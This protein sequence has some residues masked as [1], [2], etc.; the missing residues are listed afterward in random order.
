METF[1]QFSISEKGENSGKD[2][3]GIFK[4]KTLLT[5]SDMFLSDQRRRDIL[6]PNAES[7]LD[8]LKAEAFMLGQLFVR[9]V[10]SPRFWKDSNYGLELED[11]N[12]ISVLFSKCMDIETERK[13]NLSKS[14]DAAKQS[15]IKKDQSEETS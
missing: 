8:A 15:L 7:A 2:F 6:G 5:R 10:E 1:V 13:S 12:V 4:I 14:A 3:S 9:V 11:I